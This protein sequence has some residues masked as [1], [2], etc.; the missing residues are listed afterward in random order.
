MEPNVL[1]QKKEE[2]LTSNVWSENLKTKNKKQKRKI[3]YLFLAVALVAGSAL[4]SFYLSRSLNQASVPNA[5]ESQPQAADTR[6]VRGADG[7]V[8]DTG[9]AGVTSREAISSWNGGADC[10]QGCGANEY[11]ENG[12]CRKSGGSGDA[13]SPLQ[14]QLGYGTQLVVSPTRPPLSDYVCTSENCPGPEFHCASSNRCVNSTGYC[15]GLRCNGSCVRD[16][17]NDY[18]CDTTTAPSITLD[19]SNDPNNCGADGNVCPIGKQKCVGGTCVSENGAVSCNGIAPDNHDGAGSLRNCCVPGG[20]GVDP[21]TGDVDQRVHWTNCASGTT[22]RQGVG[23][24]GAGGRV[25]DNVRE[26]ELTSSTTTTVT[27]PPTQTITIPPTITTT[28][29]ATPSAT[30]TV[31]VTATPSATITVEPTKAVCNESCLI[32]SDC[33]FGLFCDSESN[34]CRKAECSTES[35]CVCPTETPEPTIV[36]C[37]KRCISDSNCSTGLKCDSESGRCRKPACSDEKD[38]SCPKPRKTDSPTREVT[39]TTTR[40]AAQP[41]VLK[42]AGIL[43]FPGAAVFGSGLLLTVIGI[44]LAL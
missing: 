2:S 18:R 26:S 11:C 16:G 39:R 24:I 22:C 6:W 37:N 30:I 19:N 21:N 31:T 42:E 4:G 10:N 3:L 41:T 25:V 9:K 1:N 20:V 27:I 29:T 44:L 13:R 40:T 34:K 38:C 43:D 28:P 35:S 12:R 33:T 14:Q 8:R 15:N 17:A 36:G 23:C 32:D 5:P 7:V